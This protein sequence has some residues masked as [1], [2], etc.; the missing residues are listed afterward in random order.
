MQLPPGD[1]VQYSTELLIAKLASHR[2]VPIIM[3]HAGTC[4]PSR[5]PVKARDGPIKKRYRPRCPSLQAICRYQHSTELLTPESD[6]RLKEAS[7]AAEETNLALL[8]DRKGEVRL[9]E[10]RRKSAQ[11]CGEAETTLPSVWH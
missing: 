11:S 9:S 5:W 2:L 6:L 1:L 8:A 10:A 7:L 4:V 3:Q